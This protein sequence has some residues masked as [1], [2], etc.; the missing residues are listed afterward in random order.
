MYSEPWF[1]PCA[2]SYQ[3]A[4]HTLLHSNYFLKIFLIYDIALCSLVSKVLEEYI[5]SVFGIEVN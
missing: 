1:H 5:S 2:L 3:H 4:F